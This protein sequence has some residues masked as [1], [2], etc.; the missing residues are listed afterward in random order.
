MRIV[1]FG[2]VLVVAALGVEPGPLPLIPKS[3]RFAVIGDNGTGEKEQYEVAAQM[4]KLRQTTGFDFVLMNGDDIYGGKSASEVKKKFELPYASLL[5][6]GVKFYATLGNHDDVNERFYK[7][8]NM[9]EKR[10]YNFKNGNVEFFALDSTYMDAAQ[11]DWLKTQLGASSAAWKV[12][13]FHHPFYSDGKFHGPDLDLRARLEP[14]FQ[15]FN[16]NVVFTGHEHFY[17]RLTPQN[18]IYYFIEGSSGELRTHNV[19]PSP[20]VG[21][22]FDTDRAFMV[23]ETAGDQMFFEAVSRTGE[24]V[25]SGKL[26]RQVPNPAA[27]K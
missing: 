27:A 4:E 14:I 20:T 7:P 8:F 26:D 25:D 1:L 13:F 3:V 19:R 12:C 2:I 10:Y 23:V 16:V 21:K 6:A 5:T 24:I 15:K 17:E 22:A 18:G 9:N 11:I